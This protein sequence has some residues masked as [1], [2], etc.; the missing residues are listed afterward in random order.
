MSM[1]TKSIHTEGEYASAMAADTVRN[2]RKN[3]V[4]FRNLHKKK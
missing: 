1:I 3:Q 2:W 4:L